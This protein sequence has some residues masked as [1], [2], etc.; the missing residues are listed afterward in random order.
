[1]NRKTFFNQI[2][3]IMPYSRF[4]KQAVA[5]IEAVLDGLEGRGVSLRHAAY[6][7]ATAH[8]ESDHWK[9]L[10]EYASGAAYEGRKDLGNVR[11]GDGKRF[12]GRGLVQI[13]G[14][15]NYRDWS[16]RL[17]VD[18]IKSPELACNLFY[19]VQILIDGCLEG[20]FTTRKL[21]DYDT[22]EDMRRVVNGTDRA[23][24][25][26]DI[27]CKYEA[28]LIVAGYGTPDFDKALPQEPH[29]EPSNPVHWLISILQTVFGKG[30]S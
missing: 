27:A 28:A 24:H 16:K 14:R 9:T 5:W 30:K 25:I 1:M 6:I 26:A 4:T 3:P 21:S 17:G 15:R 8:H 11:K 19:A 22:Y 7:L 12:K 29:P 23:K 10:E 18:L 20:T 13:T 2:R